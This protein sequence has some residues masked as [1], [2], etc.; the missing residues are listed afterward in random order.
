MQLSCRW[1]AIN[2]NVIQIDIKGIIDEI[3]KMEN[4]IHLKCKSR[5]K[6]EKNKKL[7]K[8]W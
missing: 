1:N 7:F 8:V 2:K 4:G 5:L 3:P 6:M